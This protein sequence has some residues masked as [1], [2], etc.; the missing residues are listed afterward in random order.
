MLQRL[1]ALWGHRILVEPACGAALS[2]VYA[3]LLT[4]YFIDQQDQVRFKTELQLNF[5]REKEIL[6]FSGLSG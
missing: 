1:N 2:A 5:W 3:Q 4:E 6:P